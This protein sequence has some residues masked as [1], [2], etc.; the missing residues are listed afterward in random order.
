MRI[1]MG[2]ECRRRGTIKVVVEGI[3]ERGEKEI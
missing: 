3:K 1:M 2:G